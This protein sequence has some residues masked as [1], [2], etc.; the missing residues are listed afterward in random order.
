MEAHLTPTSIDRIYRAKVK[1]KSNNF[2]P[3]WVGVKFESN[4][5]RLAVYLRVFVAKI[6]T[7]KNIN[8]AVHVNDSY[9]V[10]RVTNPRDSTENIGIDSDGAKQYAKWE[11]TPVAMTLLA[12]D[13]EAEASGLE[14]EASRLEEEASRL[15]AKVSELETTL[16]ELE[17]QLIR[18]NED[19]ENARADMSHKAVVLSAFERTY[20]IATEYIRTKN[21][22]S[23][24]TYA[25]QDATN[26]ETRKNTIANTLIN[27]NKKIRDAL[28][29]NYTNAVKMRIDAEN[30]TRDLRKAINGQN[31]Q[32]EGLKAEINRLREQAQF[33]RNAI[34]KLKKQA[35]ALRYRVEQIGPPQLQFWFGNIG[36]DNPAGK[37]TRSGGGS[38]KRKQSLGQGGLPNPQQE[39]LKLPLDDNEIEP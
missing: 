34:E 14:A 23:Q 33:Y 36:G 11:Q 19:E 18:A 5:E 20:L 31:N 39:Q 10:N 13:M 16:G 12:R 3:Q 32:V 1:L 4:S 15:E 9:F 38:S 35:Q 30:R 21:S 37:R 17:A 22:Q 26:E 24:H 2:I 8:G 27:N 28:N 25:Q 6:L 7:Q 29:E